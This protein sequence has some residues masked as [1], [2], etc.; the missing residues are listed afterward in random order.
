MLRSV[1]TRRNRWCHGR[2]LR[3]E[4]SEYPKAS[5][6]ALSGSLASCPDRRIEEINDDEA[7]A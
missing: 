2:P 4:V 6:Q 5:A 3:G 1:H 7:V